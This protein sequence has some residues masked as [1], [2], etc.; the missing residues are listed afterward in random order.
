MKQ[1]NVTGLFVPIFGRSLFSIRFTQTTAC[2][3]SNPGDAGCMQMGSLYVRRAHHTFSVSRDLVARIIRPEVSVSRSRWP[4]GL[5]SL[6]RWDRGFCV[7][8]VLCVG[9]GLATG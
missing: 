8:V 6:E 9:S 1:R 3:G 7:Y 2:A 4:R 5:P